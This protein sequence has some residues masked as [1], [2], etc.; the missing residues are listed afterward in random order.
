MDP[1]DI[2]RLCAS[3]SLSERD[4]PVRKLKDSLKIA[5]VQRMSLCLVGKVLS[6]KPVNREAF[7]RVIGRIWQ[8]QMGMEIE[9]VTGNIFMFHFKD[10]ED[11][12]KVIFGAPWSFDDALLALVKPAGKGKIE[13]IA[14]NQIEIWVQI[15]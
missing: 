10:M 1:N 14:F 3:M 15:H 13:S 8:I 7:M 2:A 12:L 9:P 5:A 4:G 6:N 11:R